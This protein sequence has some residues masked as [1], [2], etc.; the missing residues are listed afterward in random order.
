M[1]GAKSCL[2]ILSDSI[3]TDP[4]GTKQQYLEQNN[5]KNSQ[6]KNGTPS[7]AINSHPSKSTPDSVPTSRQL[8]LHHSQHPLSRR[9]PRHRLRHLP[10]HFLRH[11]H[12]LRRLQAPRTVLLS[13]IQTH[14]TNQFLRKACG[15][16]ACH[17]IRDIPPKYQSGD[18]VEQ[19]FIPVCRA[20]GPGGATDGAGESG[21]GVGN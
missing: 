18:R 17:R 6:N 7:P 4:R 11:R 1:P 12:L 9:H 14:S 8:K 20:D 5:Y 2:L 3:V 10:R 19:G 15:R 13:H 16:P 21:C